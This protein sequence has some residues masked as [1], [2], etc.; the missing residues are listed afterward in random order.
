MGPDPQELVSKLLPQTTWPQCPGQ[1]AWGQGL[2]SSGEDRRVR[3]EEPVTAAARGRP[4]CRTLRQ[5]S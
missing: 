2:A 5:A 4:T 3:R 1:G